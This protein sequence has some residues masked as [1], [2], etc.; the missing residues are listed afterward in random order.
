[1]LDDSFTLLFDK[2]G[3]L[4]QIQCENHSSRASQKGCNNLLENR[5]ASELYTAFQNRTHFLCS[6]HTQTLVDHEG[7]ARFVRAL[8]GGVESCLYVLAP[9][10]LRDVHSRAQAL[11][12]PLLRLIQSSL[13]RG[14]VI[15]DKSRK[16][17]IK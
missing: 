4:S 12:K 2:V 10:A 13:G 8:L 3:P 14:L 11:W 6:L 17:I 7:L 9:G 15:P 16:L 1:M 5:D